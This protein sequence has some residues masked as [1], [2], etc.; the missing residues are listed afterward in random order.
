MLYDSIREDSEMTPTNNV[1]VYVAPVVKQGKAE[2]QIYCFLAGGIT[3][4]W[5][6]QKAVI[7]SI[8]SDPE[9]KENLV[10]FSPRRSNFP[11]DDPNAAEEQITWE[12]KYLEQCD[13][14][15]MYFCNGDSDQPICMYELG[16]NIALMQHKFPIDWEKRIIITVEKG[17]KRTADVIIQTKLA[18]DGAVTVRVYET[19]EEAVKDHIENIKIAARSIPFDSSTK[20]DTEK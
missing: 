11:I 16:R 9:Y 12:F 7:D 6:W 13:I 18:T 20:A 8:C 10:L 4:C 5:D 19:P 15:S 1:T 17:Y 2:D 14:F 3:D